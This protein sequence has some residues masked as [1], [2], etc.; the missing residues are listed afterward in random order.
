MVSG[1]LAVITGAYFSLGNVQQKYMRSRQDNLQGYYNAVAGAHTAIADFN[2]YGTNAHSLYQS[3]QTA[4]YPSTTTD[5]TMQS[6]GTNT[7]TSTYSVTSTA[8]ADGT[9]TLNSIGTRVDAARTV[10]V[11]IDKKTHN[12]FVNAMFANDGITLSGS[13][14]TDSYNSTA[15]T[16]AAQATNFNVMMGVTYARTM[17]D[18]GTNGSLIDLVGGVKVM[19][20]AT[21][22]PSGAVSMTGS[23]AVWGSTAPASQTQYLEDVVFTAPAVNNNGSITYT[24]SDPVSAGNFNKNNNTATMPSGT[25]VFNNFSVGGSS[26]VTITGNVTLYVTG[27]FSIGGTG[28]LTIAPGASLKIFG[29]GDFDMGGTGI[30]NQNGKASSLQVYLSTDTAASTK[31]VDLGGTADFYGVVY[32]PKAMVKPHGTSATY[33]SLVGKAINVVGNS[34]FHFDENLLTLVPE[35]GFYTWEQVSWREL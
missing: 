18:L 30:A 35:F 26:D 17:G 28:A 8:N 23:S 34:T 5:A 12:A 21:P 16:Y 2:Y 27:D 20:D 13:V 19:G 10:E 6:A 33:G 31:D 3:G 32:A 7:V 11:V 22:G 24:G 29:A 9:Y 15:G 4:T 25:Y 1:A 14:I